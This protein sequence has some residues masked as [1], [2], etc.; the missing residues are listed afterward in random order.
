LFNKISGPAVLL[1]DIV[2][3][4]SITVSTERKRH[5]GSTSATPWHTHASTQRARNML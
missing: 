2:G 5:Y 4:L 1:L 3:N